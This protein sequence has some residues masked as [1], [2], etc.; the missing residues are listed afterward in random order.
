M[1]GREAANRVAARSLRQLP[2]MIVLV[3]VL[4]GLTVVALGE[5]RLGCVVVG[6]SL[7]IGATERMLLPRNETGLLQVRSRAFDTAI[8]ALAG[9]AIIALAILVPNH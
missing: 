9:A 6:A 7:G 8:M 5:W 3:G 4:V 1:P 2:L